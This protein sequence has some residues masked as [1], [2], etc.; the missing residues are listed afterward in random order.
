MAFLRNSHR[1]ARLIARIF[2]VSR[3]SAKKPSQRSR[4]TAATRRQPT[5]KRTP[6]RTPH[7][8]PHRKP[9]QRPRRNQ[10]KAPQNRREISHP[11]NGLARGRRARIP[12]RLARPTTAA[13]AAIRNRVA[14]DRGPSRG[15]PNTAAARRNRRATI[16]VRCPLRHRNTRRNGKR[17]AQFALLL[18]ARL[19][20][21]C[22]KVRTPEQANH[23]A[24]HFRLGT[25]IDLTT[26]TA[27]ATE[28]TKSTPRQRSTE[29]PTTI[30][31]DA[32]EAEKSD[33]RAT[34][35]AH[36]STR[37]SIVTGSDETTNACCD[38]F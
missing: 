11:R 23:L 3:I 31:P 34:P 6:A 19:V 27:T 36:P 26:A 1:T 4:T 25:A 16:R 24:L 13:D 12:V 15:R 9:T 28:R 17:T 7:K 18:V 22:T 5:T 32:T 21:C 2:C 29:P 10:P 35:A 14:P 8:R 20:C 30:D 33:T 37:K 38:P